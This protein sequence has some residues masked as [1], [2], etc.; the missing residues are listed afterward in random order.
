M[1]KVTPQKYGLDEHPKVRRLT[2]HEEVAECVREMIFEGELVAGSRVAEREL[3]LKFGISRTPLREAL[4]VLA[5]EALITLQPNRGA[6]ISPLSPEHL[7]ELFPL[8]G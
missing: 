1:N 7:D 6:W 2:L 3:C 4:K 5:N 8:I